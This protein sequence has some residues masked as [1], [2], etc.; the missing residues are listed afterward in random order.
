MA[1]LEKWSAAAGFFVSSEKYRS[2]KAAAKWRFYRKVEFTAME[3]AVFFA[4]CAYPAS[5]LKNS[6]TLENLFFF[7]KKGSQ[8]TGNFALYKGK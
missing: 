1:A 5:S 3:I 8:D 4:P 6:S 7:E 2:I